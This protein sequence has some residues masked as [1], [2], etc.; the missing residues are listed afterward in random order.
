[1]NP[2]QRVLCVDD[3]E[4]ILEVARLCLEMLGGLEVFCCH[5]GR[6]ALE[7]LPAIRPDLVLL[8]VMMPGLDG[9][10]TL[11]ELRKSD[12]GRTLP[13][14]FMT[15]RIRTT[16]AQEYM[17][18]GASGVVAKPF[19]P[20]TLHSEIERIWQSVHENREPTAPVAVAEGGEMVDGKH[21]SC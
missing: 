3:E 13:V 5:G 8:D 6:E 16:E 14:V 21:T 17:R 10:A 4:D 15:A 18:L 20:S 7:Q 2:L 12:F 11:L 1:M 19:D 9:P